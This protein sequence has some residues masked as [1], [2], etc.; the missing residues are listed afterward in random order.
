LAF[1]AEKFGDRYIGGNHELDQVKSPLFRKVGVTLLTHGDVLFWGE[2]VA[3]EY[4]K[5]ETVGANWF[6][7]WTCMGQIDF[8]RHIRTPIFTQHFLDTAWTF[9]KLYGCKMVICG[10]R[11]PSHA[12]RREYNGVNIVVLP[13][14]RNVIDLEME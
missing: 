12:V 8:L 3:K 13:R 14:G 10:H 9:A 5:E 1:L 4:R 6:K 7:R 11:H 2:K